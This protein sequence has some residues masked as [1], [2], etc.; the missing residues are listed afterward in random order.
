MICLN[1]S[2]SPSISACIPSPKALQ[3]MSFI[4]RKASSTVDFII[5]KVPVIVPQIF[6]KASPIVFLINPNTCSMQTLTAF[7][8]LLI[9]SEI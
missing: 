2:Q 7:Q 1:F 9:I 8:V 3:I 4:L 5:P 6:A